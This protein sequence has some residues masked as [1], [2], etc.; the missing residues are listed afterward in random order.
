MPA[1]AWGEHCAASALRLCALRSRRAEEAAR[2]PPNGNAF[3]SSGPPVLPPGK[4]I[5]DD[6]DLLWAEEEDWTNEKVR[7]STSPLE[8]RSGR[9]FPVREFY[10]L[11]FGLS[12]Q[13]EQLRLIE[14]GKRGYVTPFRRKK[15]H[16]GTV[17]NW[18]A[19][20]KRNGTRFFKNR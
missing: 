6:P 12:T 10:F 20:Y 8:R 18:D 16:E 19:F 13:D 7:A 1:A 4:H 15:L 17:K 11:F 14:Q 9:N 5:L 2:A 3:T